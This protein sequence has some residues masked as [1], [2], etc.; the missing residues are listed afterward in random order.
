M[1]NGHLGRG[2]RLILLSRMITFSLTNTYYTVL[3]G[4]LLQYTL[5]NSYNLSKIYGSR[6]PARYSFRRAGNPHGLVA[7]QHYADCKNLPLA[8]PGKFF[9]PQVAELLGDCRSFPTC[10]LKNFFAPDSDGGTFVVRLKR[11]LKFSIPIGGLARTRKPVN[12][13]SRSGLRGH[14]KFSEQICAPSQI[15]GKRKAATKVTA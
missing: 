4:T 13:I 7:I 8:P 9:A 12:S 2:L 10:P 1:P 6:L 3:L 11:L 15:C 14:R 5:G